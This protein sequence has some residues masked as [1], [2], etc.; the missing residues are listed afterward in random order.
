MPQ[1]VLTMEPIAYEY[2]TEIR[3]MREAEKP[4]DPADLDALGAQG[5]NLLGVL[6]D[7]DLWVYHFKR[8]TYSTAEQT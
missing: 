7:N 1:F 5:W 3:N 8:P 6:V 4:L 2:H